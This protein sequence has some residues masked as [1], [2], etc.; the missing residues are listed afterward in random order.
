MEAMLSPNLEKVFAYSHPEAVFT[1]L[2][3]KV[4]EALQTD[5]C[6]LQVRNPT[7]RLYRIFCWRRSPQFPDIGT[8]TW[9]QEYPWEKDDPLFAA[10][11]RS[12]PSIFVEDV[13]TAAPEVLN[14]DFERNFGH[15]ALIHA[16]ICQDEMLWGILQPCVFAHPRV[17]SEGDRAIV[18]QV[19]DRIRPW[20]I[21]YGE[22]AHL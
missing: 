2:L 15:R 6:F 19:V 3:P 17:W 10:A 1:A 11:L 22:T 7:Q 16:H 12:A 13:K 4:C 21:S 9:Q 20:V 14:L 18:A 8:E 5:R